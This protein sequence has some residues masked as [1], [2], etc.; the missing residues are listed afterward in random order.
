MPGV[1]VLAYALPLLAVPL[2]AWVW[3]RDPAN[4]SPTAPQAVLAPRL[5]AASG[6]RRW[7]RAG[8]VAPAEQERSAQLETY[9]RTWAVRTPS[10]QRHLHHLTVLH[11]MNIA[12][13]LGVG[14]VLAACST[15]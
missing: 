11:E 6:E 9:A 3:A 12:P 14:E 4:P 5:R 15:R 7:A 13:A 8:Q 2:V 10:L 1:L